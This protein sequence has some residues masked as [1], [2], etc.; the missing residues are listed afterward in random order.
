MKK[1]LVFTVIA[2]LFMALPTQA[3][4]PLRFGVKAGVNLA[5]MSLSDLQGNLNPSNYT[6][7]Q[8]GPI[9]DFTVPIVGIGMNVA[10]LYSQTGVKL[11]GI[12]GLKNG[13]DIVKNGNILIPVNFKYTLFSL[14]PL[15]SPY[16]TV[17]PYANL[18]ISDNLAS[19]IKSQSFGAGLNFGIGVELLKR[20][21][22]GANYQLGLTDDYGKSSGLQIAGS[23][24]TGGKSHVWSITAAF[25]F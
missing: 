12:T 16:A 19:D 5:S 14:I 21:Q 24:I 23:A 1:Y 10:I 25:F 6:G 2:V 3:Q 22:V 17:G 8:V 15:I 18:N 11:P 9:M 4:K 20:L 7:F 13:S